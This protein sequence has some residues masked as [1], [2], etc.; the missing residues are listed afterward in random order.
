ME[1]RPHHVL[2]IVSAHGHDAEFKAHPYGHAVHSVAEALLNDP[3]LEIEFIVGADEICTPCVHLQA[4]GQCDDMLNNLDPPV[5]KQTYNDCLDRRLF[6]YLGL[7]TGETMT[8]RQYLEIVSS[9]TPGLEEICS[10]PGE[11][12]S[13]RL[14]GL[15][16][17]LRKLGVEVGEPG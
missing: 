7:A 13:R 3:G 10:H 1:L 16:R 15:V 4:D 2:D 17:G 6:E 9:K 8:F 5:S 14:A 11:D 12:R